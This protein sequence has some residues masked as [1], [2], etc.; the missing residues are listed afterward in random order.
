[1]RLALPA[2][3]LR[4]GNALADFPQVSLEM[5]AFVAQGLQLI[6]VAPSQHVAATVIDAAAIVFLVA[7]AGVFDL[8]GAGDGARLSAELLGVVAASQV[9]ATAELSFQPVV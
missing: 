8:A 9:E 6:G 4:V 7:S 5:L 2:Q 3:S 1:L